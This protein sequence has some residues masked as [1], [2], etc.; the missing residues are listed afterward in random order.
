MGVKNGEKFWLVGF[1]NNKKD[2]KGNRFNFICSNG[3]KSQQVHEEY[4]TSHVHMMPEGAHLLIRKVEIYYLDWCI[5]GFRFF[6]SDQNEIWRIG[7]NHPLAKMETVNIAVGEVII[8]MVAKVS[9]DHQS[10]YTDF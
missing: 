4:P 6:D 10:V 8:G 2:G 7:G 1:E 9:G 5:W 3:E